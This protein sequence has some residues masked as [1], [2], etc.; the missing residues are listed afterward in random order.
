MTDYT[1]SLRLTEQDTG[2]NP[3]TW[4]TVTNAQVI[5]L[6][7]EAIAHVAEVDV[8]GT[9]DVNIATTVVNGGSDTARHAVLELTGTLGANINLITPSV[10]KIYLINALWTGAFTV[11]VKPSGGSGGIVMS[12]GNTK[13]MYING[14]SITEIVPT[15]PFTFGNGL[16][17][18]GSTVSVNPLSG[19]VVTVASGGVNVQTATTS[20][21]GV[22]QIKTPSALTIDGSGIVDIAAASISNTG[23]VQLA[24]VSD[25][26]AGTSTTLA[27]T[28][29]SLSGLVPSSIGSNGYIKLPGGLIIQWG[30][31]TG[32]TETGTTISYPIPFPSAAYSVTTQKVNSTM[33]GGAVRDSTLTSVGTTTFHYVPFISG[34]SGQSTDVYWIAL[35]S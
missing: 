18:S 12:T 10:D 6:I 34:A 15:T 9:S 2:D 8:T 25:V 1:T 22:V 11:T 14:T 3:E 4:G 28:P 7:D 26:T 23:S 13:L 33:A 5:A 29:A 17:V 32:I 24:Q 16:T 27:V 21:L 31:Q 19:G 35:G 30:T 20:L